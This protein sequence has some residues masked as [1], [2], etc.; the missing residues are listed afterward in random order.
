MIFVNQTISKLLVVFI[1]RKKTY[2]CRKCISIKNIIP[3]KTSQY[4]KT[5][6][7]RMHVLLI[8]RFLAA[9]RHHMGVEYH[10]HQGEMF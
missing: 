2:V 8:F 7:V 1:W 3:R 6:L 10:Q 5:I 4:T 9:L